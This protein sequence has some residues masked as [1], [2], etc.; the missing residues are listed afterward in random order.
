M[1]FECKTHGWTHIFDG[2]PKCSDLY[3][4][5]GSTQSVF[6][7]APLIDAERIYFENKQL[8]EENERLKK[9]LDL[10]REVSNAMANNKI[11]R[12]ENARLTAELKMVREIGVEGQ[13]KINDQAW[14]KNKKLLTA[15]RELREALMFLK[16]L[17]DSGAC[18]EV[19]EEALALHGP[20]FGEE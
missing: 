9:G 17:P 14:D 16:E 20:T 4:T 12:E 15:G 10:K 3:V 18:S 8:R 1:S 2:C 11:L 6:K 13:R 7:S 19:L 5:S